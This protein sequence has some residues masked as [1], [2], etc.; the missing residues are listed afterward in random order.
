MKLRIYSARL[1]QAGE[2]VCFKAGQLIGRMRLRADEILEN[3]PRPKDRA[4][5]KLFAIARDAE[6]A[7]SVFGMRDPEA[8]RFTGGRLRRIEQEAQEIAATIRQ[9]VRKVDIEPRIQN[10]G[11]I[12]DGLEEAVEAERGEK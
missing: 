12:I 11:R 8:G 9:G 3:L 1:G 2:S 6:K 10:L 5:G 7:L 4:I